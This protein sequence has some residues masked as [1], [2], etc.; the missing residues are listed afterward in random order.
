MV[1]GTLLLIEHTVYCSFMCEI[2]SYFIYLMVWKNSTLMAS[3]IDEHDDGWPDPAAVVDS[4]ECTRSLV[5][6]SRR[7]AAS[8]EESDIFKEWR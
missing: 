5:A 3:A 4:T 2:W 7:T 8:E 6:T 1:L